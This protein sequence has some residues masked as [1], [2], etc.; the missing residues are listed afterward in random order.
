MC[1]T[2]GS[3][4]RGTQG[5]LLVAL[6]FLLLAGVLGMHGWGSHGV[7]S[8]GHVPSAHHTGL[9]ELQHAAVTVGGVVGE[10]MS[11][12]PPTLAG[13]PDFGGMPLVGLCVAVLS[14]VGF[15]LLL[16]AALRW[17]APLPLPPARPW[18]SRRARGRDR[19]PP[20]LARL[21]VLRR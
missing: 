10:G 16:L 9:A 2:I 17:R 4:Q 5:G 6:L 20:S 15:V 18:H 11:A 7:T 8:G 21:S 3:G 13:R 1:R 14:P 19:D 12:D